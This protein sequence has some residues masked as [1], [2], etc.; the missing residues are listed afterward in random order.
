MVKYSATP[1]D[2]KKG[3]RFVANFGARAFDDC[4]GDVVS[5]SAWQ[6]ASPELP[7]VGSP[8]A[9][10]CIDELAGAGDVDRNRQA[11][12]YRVFVCCA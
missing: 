10:P 2:D 9:H 4:G 5:C 7:F 6:S 1:V 11:R 8:L 3:E 12:Y